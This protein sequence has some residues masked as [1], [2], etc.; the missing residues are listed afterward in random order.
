MQL[1]RGIKASFAPLS[2]TI[3]AAQIEI[4]VQGKERLLIWDS[5]VGA[6]GREKEEP[7]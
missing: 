3:R 4:L 6:S 2:G 7:E 5:S 1:C